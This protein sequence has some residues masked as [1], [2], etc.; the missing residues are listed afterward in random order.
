MALLTNQ[1]DDD[2]TEKIILICCQKINSKCEE[3]R[4]SAVKVI[5]SITVNVNE[6]EYVK[7]IWNITM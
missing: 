6:G 5:Q 7:V 3:I 4:S 2:V 1:Y